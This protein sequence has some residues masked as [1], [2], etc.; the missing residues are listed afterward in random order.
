[1]LAMYPAGGYAVFVEHLLLVLMSFRP[2]DTVSVASH[3]DILLN[4]IIILRS[5]RQYRGF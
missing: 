5:N 2:C 4:V 3:V 1:M